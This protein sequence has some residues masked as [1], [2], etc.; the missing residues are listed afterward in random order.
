MKDLALRTT[1][2]EV[3]ELY[4]SVR[5]HYPD[6]LFDDLVRTTNLSSHSKLLEIG[7]GTGQATLSLAR[8]GLDITAIE[9]GSR[10]AA[11][12][13]E[14]LHDY[15]AVRIVTGAFEDVEL[16]AETFDLVYSA[17]AFH[18]I[19]REARF[20]KPHRILRPNGYLAIITGSHISDG[21]DR[22]FQATQP[23]YDTYLPESSDAPAFRLKELSDVGPAELDE[24]LF[25]RVL[26]TCFPRTITYT[27]DQYC[28]L[29]H[30]ESEKLALS[31]DKRN[32]FLTEMAE[33]IN[34]QSKGVAARRYA[35]VMT[36][37]RR[38]S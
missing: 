32:A 18:W 12:A 13:R 27:A 3:A 14:N 28:A 9:L 24:S 8:L 16:P 5:P 4:D 21:D 34:S 1:F 22:F 10:L 15:P 25:R 36:V 30:T 33:L 26:F 23:L 37:A 17:T 6:E 35:N 11:I 31:P 7:P 38:V 19:K 29:L 20:S 2:D